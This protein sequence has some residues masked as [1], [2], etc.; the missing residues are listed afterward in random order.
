MLTAAERA[1]YPAECPT[2]GSPDPMRHPA[3]QFGGE[4]QVCRDKFHPITVETISDEQIES[5]KS[6]AYDLED[7]KLVRVCFV[8]LNEH[9]SIGRAARARCAEILNARSKEQR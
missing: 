5:L 2:C 6:D 3:M 8:A 7:G 1:K 9:S 4:V